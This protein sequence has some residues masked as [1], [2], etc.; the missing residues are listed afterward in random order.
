MKITRQ[1][2]QHIDAV[3]PL[4]NTY[5]QTRAGR[6]RATAGRQGNDVLTANTEIGAQEANIQITV[7]TQ[8]AL[9]LN[10]KF[11]GFISVDF[12]DQTFDKNLRTTHVKFVNHGPDLPVLR[13]RRSDDQGIGGRIGLDLPTRRGLVGLRS[14][15][16][17][18]RCRRRRRGGWAAGL[19]SQSRAQG[20][21][22]FGGFGIFQIDHMNIASIA[23]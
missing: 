9:P 13:F 10:A 22:N 5:I 18:S 19:T 3:D 21:G 2:P 15:C 1:E 8:Q 16:C 12:G 20:R 4:R 14:P 17:S 6:Y 23:R 11:G 7:L